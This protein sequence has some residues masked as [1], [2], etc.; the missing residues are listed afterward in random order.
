MINDQL[1]YYYQ[2]ESVQG[3]NSIKSK[4]LLHW[5]SGV[6][7][8]CESFHGT[9]TFALIKYQTTIEI[10]EWPRYALF[11]HGRAYA[12]RKCSGSLY[13]ESCCASI[14][15]WND[16]AR[17]NVRFWMWTF[18]S[19]SLDGFVWMDPREHDRPNPLWVSDPAEYRKQFIHQIDLMQ[20]ILSSHPP[21][22]PLF[23]LPD[24]TR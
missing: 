1:F 17:R 9:P 20:S 4:V 21:P 13:S 23:F 19:F 3:D 18:Q 8:D 16:A 5:A 12:T 15:I 14:P 7:H 24:C 6:N 10:T 2:S 22:A 11:T